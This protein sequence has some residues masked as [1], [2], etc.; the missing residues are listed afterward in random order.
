M[1]AML[2]SGRHLREVGSLLLVKWREGRINHIKLSKLPTQMGAISMK[3]RVRKLILKK[4]HKKLKFWF[5]G[6]SLVFS[7]GIGHSVI[8]MEWWNSLTQWNYLDF[9][10]EIFLSRDFQKMAA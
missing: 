3:T 7:F 5:K 4:E 1:W 9:W 2:G 6:I 8:F 10:V